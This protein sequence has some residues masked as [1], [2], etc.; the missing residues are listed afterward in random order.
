MEKVKY[1]YE[2]Y[3]S[4]LNA[5]QRSLK[6]FERSDV[7]ED[8]K[9]ELIASL[10]KH[11]ELCYEIVWKF[12][13]IYLEKR[14]S[15]QIDSPKKVFRRCFELGLI[16]Q[17]TTQELLGISEARNATS[18]DYDEENAQETCKRIKDFSV[19]FE[20]ISKMPLKFTDE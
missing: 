18:H 5:L 13:K 4:S 3:L 10:V 2:K 11:Y 1:K 17:N 19:T 20:K 16:D 6:T 7:P 8:I 14:F 9:N 12:L 15:E